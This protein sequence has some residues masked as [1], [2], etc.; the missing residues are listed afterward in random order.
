V[1]NNVD[2]PEYLTFAGGQRRAFTA[3]IRLVGRK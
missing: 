2:S 1:I 3:R